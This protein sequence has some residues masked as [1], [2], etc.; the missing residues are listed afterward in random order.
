MHEYE[1]Y[2][3]LH[4]IILIKDFIRK[5]W[6]VEVSLADGAGQL[7]DRKTSDPIPPQNDF[8]RLSLFCREGN[9]RC[10]QSARVL[11]E[12]FHVHRK[13]RHCLSHECHLGLQIIAAPLYLGCEYAGALVVEGFLRDKLTGRGA[14]IL[15]RKIRDLND[16][17]T[18]LD[19]GVERIP[20]L[21]RAELDK[22]SDLLER[23]ANEI[24]SFESEK[25]RAAE[26]AVP[27]R[28]PLHE[29]VE[30]LER[31]M[32]RSGLTR[33]KGNRSQLA[34]ELG[35]SRSNLILKIGLYGLK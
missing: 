33:T 13:V 32:I 19:R 27:A 35:I 30:R 10:T 29:A 3:S 12:K 24:A 34:R 26:M 17:A 22:L 23:G 1:K 21:D 8:C 16:G 2:Q 18:D 20:L 9:R 15:K 11:L 28:E 25:L 7:L 5:W 14:E 6:R 4:T 31:D